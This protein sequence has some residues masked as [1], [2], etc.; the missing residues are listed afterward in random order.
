MA[1]N[2]RRRA[3][4]PSSARWQREYPRFLPIE[5]K[6]PPLWLGAKKRVE[7]ERPTRWGSI[8]VG[9]SLL[10]GFV[11]GG[12][13]W[14]SQRGQATF[15]TP[16]TVPLAAPPMPQLAVGL[17]ALSGQTTTGAVAAQSPVL[18][19]S[20]PQQLAVGLWPIT[21]H[22]PPDAPAPQ[23]VAGAPPPAEPLR[24]PALPPQPHRKAAAHQSSLIANPS[25]SSGVVKF[26]PCE[27]ML[28]SKRRSRGAM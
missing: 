18:G 28:R 20:Q 24:S 12:G 7:P 5:T 22:L 17:R 23:P 21:G 11:I 15:V 6:P 25:H 2:R 19:P 9:V 26:L 13:Y 27:R 8:V 1:H 16:A 3:P 14:L 4:S 10:L